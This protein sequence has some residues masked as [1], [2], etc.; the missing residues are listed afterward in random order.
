MSTVLNGPLCFI[1]PV[2]AIGKFAEII[3]ET[4]GIFDVFFSA[5]VLFFLLFFAVA[6]IICGWEGTF[7]LADDSDI[8][9]RNFLFLSLACLALQIGI[10]VFICG[11]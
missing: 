4:H 3:S 10:T 7:F 6:L 1:S 11:L 2:I 9:P 5:A 8:K